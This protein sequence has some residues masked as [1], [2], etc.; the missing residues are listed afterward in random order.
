MA[1]DALMSPLPVGSTQIWK[2]LHRFGKLPK[3]G[4]NLEELFFAI[5]IF[6]KVKNLGV[7]F[8]SFE[9][10]LAAVVLKIIGLQGYSASYT[11][12]ASCC[13]TV[14]RTQYHSFTLAAAG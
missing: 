1:Y 8:R 9:M 5:S 14:R 13:N 11:G 7:K 3:F 12:C 2:E 4:N 6:F 10:A